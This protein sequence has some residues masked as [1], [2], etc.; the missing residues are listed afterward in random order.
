MKGQITVTIS[1]KEGI[2]L[3]SNESLPKSLTNKIVKA[4]REANVTPQGAK[5]AVVARATV[6]TT[7]KTKA[8]TTTTRAAKSEKTESQPIVN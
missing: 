3:I 7:T 2:A 1:A 5:A 6:K 4:F 8:P